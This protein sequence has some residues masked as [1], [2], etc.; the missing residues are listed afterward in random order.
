MIFME[1]K[2]LEKNNIHEIWVEDGIVIDKSVLPEVTEEH[3]KRTFDVIEKYFTEVKTEKKRVMAIL[4]NIMSMTAQS[5]DTTSRLVGMGVDRFAVVTGNSW[6]ASMV[7]NF[8][9]RITPHEN[10][11]IK[12]FKSKDKAKKWLL[13]S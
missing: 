9:L 11:K 6:I 7:I 12:I 10:L 8:Y 13:E 2:I 1:K 5:K 3:V 4:S